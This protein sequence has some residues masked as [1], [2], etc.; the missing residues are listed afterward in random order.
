MLYRLQY[1]TAHTFD[2]YMTFTWRNNVQIKVWSGTSAYEKTGDLNV[3]LLAGQSWSFG[4][5]TV[6]V[7]SLNP[8]QTPPNAVLTIARS[9][10]FAWKARC[11]SGSNCCSG[12]C[13]GGKCTRP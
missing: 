10:C 13:A 1:K 3:K 7:N 5:V 9:A 6:T 2:K 11:T 12:T 8:S 4:G